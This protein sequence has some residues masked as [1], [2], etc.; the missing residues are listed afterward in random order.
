MEYK[1]NAASEGI[2]IGKALVYRPF[3]P[4]V[5][6][7]ELSMQEVEADVRHLIEV[8]EQCAKELR[9][10]SKELATVD[11]EKA[12]IFDAHL[13]ILDDEQISE[14]ISE[15]IDTEKVNADWATNLVYNKYIEMLGKSK[16]A[17]S[18]ERASDLKDVLN[19][20][21]RVWANEPPK[22][23]SCLSEPVIVIA[24]DLVPSD[25][26]SMNRKFVQAI[27]GE[28]GSFTSHSAIIAR[29][30]EIP[31]VLGVND[32]C[33][34]ICDGEEIVVNGTNGSVITGPFEPDV[35]EEYRARQ[36]HFMAEKESQQVFFSQE[37][38]TKDGTRIEIGLNVGND[39]SKEK[40][41]LEAI[42][43]IGL[44]RTEFL[45]MSASKLPDEETQFSAYKDLIRNFAGKTIILRTMDIGGD[46]QL[47]CMDL[48]QEENPFLGKRALRLCFEEQ[49]MFKT[50][51]RAALRA[52][53]FGPLQIM[54]PMVG[55]LEDYRRAKTI[56]EQASQELDERKVDYNRKIK[57]GVMVEIPSIALMATELAKEVDF[58]SIGS[59]DLC[60]YTHAV[61]RCNSSVSDYYQSFSPALLRLIAMVAKAFAVEQKPLS[62]CGEIGGQALITPALVGMG[63]KKLSMSMS[64][65]VAVKKRL[66]EFELSEMENIADEV[67]KCETQDK[68]LEILKNI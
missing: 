15:I 61:D 13:E 25:T 4:E 8:K 58:A 56:L 57:V 35:L 60:Q 28:T 24:H 65:I 38:T 9:E 31:A 43:F 14:E 45:Y 29:G 30:F 66:S 17:I 21:L 16:S 36:I 20:I 7:C 27:V 68:V 19:R 33:S 59:N 63:V 42:D 46:K 53:V 3:L 54:F 47:P 55:S 11:E 52:S 37:A 10:L 41:H 5:K 67:L 50:Q 49:E 26:V 12:K 2:A 6:R 1:G 39:I 22:D 32:I 62:I 40:E 18:R 34:D 23:L 44:F 51:L 64:S 48:P